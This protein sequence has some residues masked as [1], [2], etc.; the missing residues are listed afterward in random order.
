MTKLDASM[1]LAFRL[2]IEE[3]VRSNARERE[4]LEQAIKSTQRNIVG[5]FDSNERYRA[6]LKQLHI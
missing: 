1:D 3:H 4:Q 5:A 6:K 2:S